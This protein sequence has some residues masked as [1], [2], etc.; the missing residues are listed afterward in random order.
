[1]HILFLSDN[2]PPESNAPANRTF[3]HARVWVEMGHQVTVITC[4]PNF[5][6]G[7]VFPGYRN[8]LWQSE[9][10][11][12]IRVVRV[13]SYMTRNEGF[14]LRV[15]DYMSFMIA[16]FFA[17]LPIRKVD[18]VVGTS[19]QFFTVFAAWAAAALKRR[20]FVFELRDIWP[21]SIK[22]VNAVK[23][24]WMLEIFEKI[25][26]FLYRRASRVICVTYA[27]TE[28]LVQRGV[29]RHKL[30][31]I[32]NGVETVH[33]SPRAKAPELLLENCLEGK[34]VVGYIGTLG[35]A[36]S[37]DTLL[38]MAHILGKDPITR[39]V[40]VVILGEGAERAR[41][42]ARIQAENLDNVL[43]LA[44]VPREQVT[45]YWSLLDLAIIHL[46]STDLF[47]AVIPSKLFECM[48]MG[49]PVLHG[50]E[51]ESAD[52]VIENGVG[53]TVPPED[54]ECMA[55]EILDLVANP[56]RLKK[57][58]LAGP[59]A[60]KKYDRHILAE[61]MADCLQEVVSH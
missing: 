22:A 18:V 5:P 6:T 34:F 21:E 20:P 15:L 49:I 28:N 56:A 59:N 40:Q 30:R 38:D 48:A 37:L 58:R 39:H 50:V 60:A 29:S 24:N 32:T 23:A 16:A 47:K 7:K 17:A 61:E 11:A 41:L 36:H 27:F 26:L 42:E 53:I 10:I 54:A 2:F 31:V 13:W 44:S 45:S 25:E 43:L 8:H 35:M 12:G 14:A 46:K 19:P 52:I 33:F 51:G 57:M 9:E 1:M 55:A 3:E 4:A